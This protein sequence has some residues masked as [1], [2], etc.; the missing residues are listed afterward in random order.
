MDT[1]IGFLFALIVV[2]TIL[3]YT[4]SGVSFTMPMFFVIAKQELTEQMAS[5][6]GMTYR[7]IKGS[8]AQKGD[9]GL[10]FDEIQYSS[11]HH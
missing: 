8:D 7:I 10:L 2:Y 4:L 1:G 11:P 9:Y 5:A 3:E 6:S